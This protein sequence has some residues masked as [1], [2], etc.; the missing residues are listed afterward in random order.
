MANLYVR[1][2]DGS[3]ADNGSTWA[4]AKATIAGASAID[5]AGDVVY[6]SQAHAESGASASHAFAGTNANPVRVLAGNDAA[7]P[8]TAL[9]TAPTL[10]VSGT[11]FSWQGA[12][13]TYGL[14]FI[15]SSASSWAWAFNDSTGFRQTFQNCNFQSNGAGTGSSIGFGAPGIGAANETELLNCGIR[16]GATGQRI[17]VNRTLTIRSGSWLSGGTSPTGV[18]T[19]AGGFRPSNLLVEGFD[20]SNLSAG[21]NLVQA[22]NEGGARAVFRNCKLPAS[23]SGSL[24]ASGQVSVGTRIEM[25]NCDSGDTNY[26]LWVESYE[27][28]IRSETTIVR[29]GGASDGT[30]GLSWR[31]VSTANVSYPNN[32]LTSPEIVRWNDTTGSS[33]TVTVE[34]VTDDVTL[35]DAECWL[36]VQYL[37]TSGFPLGVTARDSKTD[38]LASA[39]NQASSSVTWTTT[40]LTTPTKQALSVTFTPQEKGFI[41]AT[42]KLAKSST[43]VYVCPKLDVT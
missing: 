11:T 36:E 16:L 8:P 30:T 18:F 41:Q 3:N 23:W 7:E 13:Y 31:M 15:A 22:V 27:G 14:N 28:S 26:R 39:A 20:F 40:G 10:T 32:A 5:A 37:G 35:T 38:V 9:S 33:I 17:S 29:T 4:L 2:T 19:I 34:V 24:V 6:V 12:V 1:S 42:V 25:H 43:T 21:V